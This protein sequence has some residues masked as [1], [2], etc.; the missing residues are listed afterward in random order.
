MKS[1]PCFATSSFA[2]R[3]GSVTA[4]GFEQREFTA[5]LQILHRVREK[6]KETNQMGVVTAAVYQAMKLA[7]LDG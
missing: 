5:Q 2:L 6:D 4:A 3:C 7:R 1:G